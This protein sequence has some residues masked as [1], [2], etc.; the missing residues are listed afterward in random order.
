[1]DELEEALASMQTAWLAG[2]SAL[3]AVP[4]AWRNATGRDEIAALALAG[5]AA[6]VL[7]YPVPSTV[8]REIPLLPALAVALLPDA[9][10][11]RFRRLLALIRKDGAL[12]SALIAFVLSRGYAAHPADWMPGVRDDWVPDVYGPWLDWVRT[13]QSR[14]AP[15]EIITPDNYD[16]WSWQ[17]KRRRL[18]DLRISDPAAAREIIAAKAASEPA[19]RRLI[20][21]GLLGAGLSE[22]DVP[23]LEVLAGDRSVRV[24]ALAAGLLGRLGRGAGNTAFAEELAASVELRSAGLLLRRKK[25]FFVELKTRPQK[26]RRSELFG[27]VSLR[28]LSAALGVEESLLLQSLPEGSASDLQDFVACVA[29]SG[30][31]ASVRSLIALLLAEKDAAGSLL[32]PL[33]E[34]LTDPDQ[35]ALVASYSSRDTDLFATTFQLAGAWTGRLPLKSV[36]ASPSYQTM[37][38]HLDA[39]VRGAEKTMATAENLLPSALL[40]LG[41][42][43]ESAGARALL[44][45]CVGRGMSPADPRLEML[46]FNI[47]LQREPST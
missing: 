3:D 43:L 19:D 20:L 4:P 18:A 1:M 45:A 24:Q 23:F 17:D 42:L 11:G 38:E 32:V 16:H 39:I 37:S 6:E 34:R 46:E 7:S 41:L 36:A 12:E 15:D 2:R 44:A 27:L 33:A 21:A 10:R 29:T 9:F 47:E 26:L 5:H 40:R 14:V 25:L 31:E 13:D 22:L 35:Q 8:L 28:D 30:T